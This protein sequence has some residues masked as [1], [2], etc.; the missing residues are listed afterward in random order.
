MGSS[1]H[2]RGA[3]TRRRREQDRNGRDSGRRGAQ[4][5]RSEPHGTGARLDESLELLCRQTALW[6]D[7]DDDLAREGQRHVA[8]RLLAPTRAGRGRGRRTRPAPETSAVVASGR[9][10]GNHA[11]RACFAAARAASSQRRQDRS[12]RSPRQWVTQCAAAHGTITSTPISV[13]SS[14][15]SSPRSPLGR[16]WTTVTVG[17]GGGCEVTAVASTS[18]ASLPAD[19]LDDAVDP[20]PASVDERDGAR[21]AAIRRTVTA[22]RPS[23]PASGRPSRPQQRRPAPGR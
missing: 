10:S 18:R 23:A 6:P 11:R 14:T 8:D 16:A 1:F 19:R 9:T 7:D 12:A 3:P 15:A 20:G 21:P 5:G 2:A 22:W 4:H 17:R 13:S